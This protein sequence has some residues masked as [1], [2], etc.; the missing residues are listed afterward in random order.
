MV[1]KF[2]KENIFLIIAILIFAGIMVA[3]NVMFTFSCDDWYWVTHQ[4]SW[5]AITELNGRYFGSILSMALTK[6]K[7]LRVALCA[8]LTVVCVY[9]I[10]ARGEG[11]RGILFVLAA[12]LFCLMP[13]ELFSETS[14]WASGFA[15][16]IPSAAVVLGYGVMVKKEFSDECPS[17]GKAAPFLAAAM[18]LLGAFFL[19]TVTIG[20]LVVGAA[21]LIYHLIRFKKPEA[22]HIA[23]LG[24]A[25]VGAVLMFI[26]PAYFQILSGNDAANYRTINFSSIFKAYIDSYHDGLIFDNF[27]LNVTLVFSAAW[28][29]GRRLFQF[30]K[31]A[32]AAVFVCAA[33]QVFF[34]VISGI[35][36]FG[37]NLPDFKYLGAFK[38]MLSFAY[39]V[40]LFAEVL[41]AAP[42]K[43]VK[44]ECLFIFGSILAYTLPLL[45]VTPIK[46]RAFIYSYF[47]FSSLV[48]ILF[49]EGLKLCSVKSHV[50][51]R[52]AAVCSL[53]VIIASS[54][55]YIIKYGSIYSAFTAREESIKTQL[56]SGA[57]EIAISVTDITDRIGVKEF[58]YVYKSEHV[59][60]YDLKYFKIYYNI[61][62]DMPLVDAN[63]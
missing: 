28:V 61:P 16:Y 30:K 3:L 36:Y 2:L 49:G 46:T 60:T 52:V 38:G 24:G 4:F 47:L 53:C 11:G 1:K 37:V 6:V 29:A 35:E 21:I 18:G 57:K 7:W 22:T 12:A 48:V 32:V 17:Y 63:G 43:N 45:V 62:E 31:P 34:L 26:D 20:N 15:N 56:A 8:V 19:E 25:I 13:L 23:F 9:L 39:F 51:E 14:A 59:F 27:F 41:I 5:E 58:T 40:S 33:V 50:A 54:A 10:S 44:L 42:G 55:F